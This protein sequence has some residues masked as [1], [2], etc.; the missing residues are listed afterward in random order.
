MAVYMRDNE[1]TGR[2]LDYPDLYRRYCTCGGNQPS[3]T[4]PKLD[5]HES[6]CRYRMEVEKGG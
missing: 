1:G 2:R 6:W 4:D 3:R 5:L